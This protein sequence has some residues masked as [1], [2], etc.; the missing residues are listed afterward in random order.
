MAGEV[1]VLVLGAVADPGLARL[2]LWEERLPVVVG[3][4]G[5][6]AAE[7][8]LEDRGEGLRRVAGAETFGEDR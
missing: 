8:A 5:G 3:R 4:H 7:D 2:G 6:P 1:R